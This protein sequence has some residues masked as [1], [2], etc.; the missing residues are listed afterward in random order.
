M[1]AALMTRVRADLELGI[2][3]DPRV[4]GPHDVIVEVA[5]CGIC[6]TDLHVLSGRAYAP[7]LPF[8][9]GH[10][11]VGTV[12]AVGREVG[13]DLVGRRVTITLFTGCGS[14]RWCAAGDERLCPD[15]FGITGVVGSWGGFAEFMRVRSAQLVTVPPSLSTCSAAALVDAGATAHNAVRT[16]LTADRPTGRVVVVGGGPVGFLAAGL[17]RR[18]GY[19]VEVVEPQTAR[20]EAAVGAGFSSVASSDEILGAPDLVIDCSGAKE[21]IAWAVGTLAPQGTLIIVGYTTIDPLDTAS[22]ARKELVVRGVRSGSRFDL[23]HVM[24]LA[25]EGEIP[26]PPVDVWPLEEIN[27]ALSRLRAGAVPGKVVIEVAAS[28][29]RE[30]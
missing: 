24:E 19:S 17:A 26:L 15:L 14:C 16:A 25:A 13:N 8:V 3:E 21:V 10:E 22:I 11:P 30:G 18:A 5:A 23:Q 2:V 4:D 29:D 27:L 1:R 6:G 12:V 28:G 7:E 9:L 20:R